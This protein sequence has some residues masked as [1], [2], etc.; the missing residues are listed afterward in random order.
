MAKTPQQKLKSAGIGRTLDKIHYHVIENPNDT[1]KAIA[2]K[3]VAP[4][5]YVY[6]YSKIRQKCT[7]NEE[8]LNAI[9]EQYPHNISGST[10]PQKQPIPIKMMS[11]YAERRTARGK[12]LMRIHAY[13]QANPGCTIPQAVA[14]LAETEYMVC[15]YSKNRIF[16]QGVALN[17][18]NT[19]NLI[20]GV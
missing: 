9:Q 11:I 15:K 14:E 10:V 2:K 17:T 19:D 3:E 7:T 12:R 5:S 13:Y 6:K 16:F 1:I 8:I 4:L 20:M 18:N